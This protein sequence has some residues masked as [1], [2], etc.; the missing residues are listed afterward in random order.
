MTW[1]ATL[2][3]KGQITLPKAMREAF[4]LSAG[5]RVT[6]EMAGNQA[7]L[8][9]AG[10]SVDAAFGILQR[11]GHQAVTIDQMDEAIRRRMRGSR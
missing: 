3:S 7:T 6:F 1:T 5:S 4:G 9:P 10:S 11:T 8:R 2:T